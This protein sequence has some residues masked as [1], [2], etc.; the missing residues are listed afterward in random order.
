MVSLIIA[1]SQST[2]VMELCLILLSII[3]TGEIPVSSPFLTYA[4]KSLYKFQ[5]I[6]CQYHP[7]PINAIILEYLHEFG[8]INTVKSIFII[9]PYFIYLLIHLNPNFSNSKKLNLYHAELSNTAIQNLVCIITN[10]I[11][12]I[13]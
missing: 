13:Y 7:P 12:T 6:Y 10:R 4:E 3:D 5:I 2:V 1:L 9:P 8:Q 11:F